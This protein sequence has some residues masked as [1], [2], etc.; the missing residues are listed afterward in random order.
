MD[1]KLS[2]TNNHQCPP[3]KMSRDESILFLIYIVIAKELRHT[4]K[5]SYTTLPLYSPGFMSLT[6]MGVTQQ[7]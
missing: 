6:G 4:Q 5:G 2:H 1:S 3:Q 7:I